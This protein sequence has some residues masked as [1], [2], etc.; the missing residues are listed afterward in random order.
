MT[1]RDKES[2]V[3]IQVLLSGTFPTADKLFKILLEITL[4]YYSL[5]LGMKL[6]WLFLLTEHGLHLNMGR[7]RCIM[8]WMTWSSQVIGCFFSGNNFKLLLSC[9]RKVIAAGFLKL[10]PVNV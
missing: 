3:F 6:L 4:D 2:E 7:L 8:N 9:N 1:N 10:D 5:K